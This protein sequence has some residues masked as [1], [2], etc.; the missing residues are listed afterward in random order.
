MAMSAVVTRSYDNARSGTTYNETILTAAAV[1]QRGI[2]RLFSIPLPGDAR[3]TEGQPLIAPGIKCADGFTHDL[4]LIA[5]MGNMLY[6]FDA[7]APE[8]RLIWAQRLGNPVRGSAKID[9]WK[10]NTNWGILST[11][12]IDLEAGVIFVV[13]YS[14][15]TGDYQDGAFFV[16]MIDLRDGAP[17]ATP[18]S[19]EN[20]TDARGNKFSGVQ[21]KQRAGLLIT[22]VGGKKTLFIGAGSIFESLASNLGWLIAVDLA[23]FKIIDA[24]TTCPKKGGG[25]IWMGSQGPAADKAGNVYFVTGNGH[26]DGITE[27]A[28]CA[29][30]AKL[31]DG[32]LTIDDWFCPFSDDMRDGAKA[33]PG[34]PTNMNGWD[35]QDLGSAGLGLIP[36]F[37]LAINSGKDGIWYVTHM[38]KMGK[39]TLADLTAGRQFAALAS[40][41]G[42][43]TYYPGPDRDPAPADPTDLNFNFGGVTHHMHSSPCHYTPEGATGRHLSFCWGEN[44]NLR[45]WNLQPSGELRYRGASVE[46][47]SWEQP[48]MP[49]GMIT[50]SANGADPNSGIVWGLTPSRDANRVISPGRLTAHSA[51]NLINTPAGPTMETLWNSQDWNVGYL[52][53]KFAIATVSGGRVFVP[54]YGATVDVYGLTPA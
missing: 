7:N 15:P 18:L 22:N 54:T 12:V 9:N 28:E 51:T 10:I 39:T 8:P 16:H 38:A 27:F 30:R 33:P 25:G 2:V 11:P 42:W 19:L 52:H 5:T 53:N 36:D 4:V 21:R 13:A 50:C 34:T 1:R 41:P 6:A 48:G 29:A 26:F 20:A 24:L 14:S 44:G 32:K 47:A 37:G 45:G 23:S 3:G 31:A 17:L 49:G 35:D 40:P 46:T 43:F